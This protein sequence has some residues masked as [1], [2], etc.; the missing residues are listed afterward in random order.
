MQNSPTSATPFGFLQ[1]D[2]EPTVL[3]PQAVPH[4]A[5]HVAAPVA[6]N[7]YDRTEN[8]PTYAPLPKPSETEVWGL[9]FVRLTTPETVDWIHQLVAARRPSYVIT[10]NLNWLMLTAQN[11][12]LRI[13]NE[14]AAGIVADGMPIVWR[15]RWSRK[16]PPL[17]ERVAGSELIYLLAERAAQAG[18]RIYMTGGAPGVAEEAARRL[19]Q[20]YPGLQIAGTDSPPFRPLT[21]AEQIDQIIKIRESKADML[22]VAYGQPKGELWIHRHYQSTEVPVS[23]QLGASFDF[24]AGT[25]RRAPLIWQRLG[26]EWFYRMASDPKRLGPRYAANAKFLCRSLMA[27]LRLRF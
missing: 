19:V 13:V 25:A 7:E 21:E 5:A 8:H 3:A 24:V 18:L 17:P 26:L 22:W 14:G 11:A 9:P 23:M 16:Q 15:S 2:L 12:E 6:P 27:E 10:A 1:N 4:A 20:R